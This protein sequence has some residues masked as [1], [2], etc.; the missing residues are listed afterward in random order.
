MEGYILTIQEGYILSY[1]KTS[2]EEISCKISCIA[3]K[4]REGVTRERVQVTGI[5]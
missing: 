5:N 2:D 3:D 1:G 4:R